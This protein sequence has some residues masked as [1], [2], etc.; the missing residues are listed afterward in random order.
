V[1][2]RSGRPPLI[3]DRDIDVDIDIDDGLAGRF[4][5]ERASRVGTMGSSPVMMRASRKA[6]R[7]TVAEADRPVPKDFA[8]TAEI[9]LRMRTLTAAS[10]TLENWSSSRSGA[11]PPPTPRLSFVML[12]ASVTLTSTWFDCEPFCPYQG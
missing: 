3:I 12:V 11:M 6:R 4:V 7:L 1:K 5:A 8:G 10:A 9:A 2:N